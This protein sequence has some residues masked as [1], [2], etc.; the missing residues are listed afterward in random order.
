MVR[1]GGETEGT[2]NSWFVEGERNLYSIRMIIYCQ[3]HQR[4]GK[5]KG[6]GGGRA[7]ECTLSILLIIITTNDRVY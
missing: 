4:G 1:K 6:K 5:K 2:H 3:S 7:T